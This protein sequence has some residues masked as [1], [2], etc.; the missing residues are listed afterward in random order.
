LGE[1]LEQAGAADDGLQAGPLIEE[2]RRGE[3]AETRGVREGGEEEA[4][5][6]RVGGGARD[7]AFDLSATVLD[8][9]VVLDAGGAGGH[10][11]HAA[12]AVVHVEAEGLVEGRV[13]LG[14]GLHH[15]DA[16]AGRVHFFAPEDVG[17]TG[18]EAEAAVDAVGDKCGIGS[19]V[20]VE[21]TAFGGLDGGELRHG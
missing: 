1:E 5:E 21:G 10:A 8:E 16:A 14:G 13:A 18:G 11:G 2:E 6:E 7:V 19:V 4:A 9:L 15:V 3:D 20:R 12:E 17:G